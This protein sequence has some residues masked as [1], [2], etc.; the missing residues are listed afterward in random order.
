MA[1]SDKLNFSKSPERI[2][3]FSYGY[4]QSGRNGGD[5]MQFKLHL[6][7][8][9]SLKVIDESTEF[10]DIEKIN[11]KLR[12]DIL[13][14][15]SEILKINSDIKAIKDI[16]IPDIERKITLLDKEKSIEESKHRK[17]NYLLL[18]LNV[19]FFTGLTLFLFYFYTDIIYEVYSGKSKK[20]GLLKWTDFIKVITVNPQYLLAPSIIGA[21]GV[22]IHY[23]IESKYKIKNILV[24]AVIL[25]T[26]IVD[27]FFGYEIHSRMQMVR[28][29]YNLP[30][31]DL[32]SNPDFYK[33][34]V[35]GFL[36]YIFWSILLHSILSQLDKQGQIDRAV[37]HIKNEI[38]K[39]NEKLKILKLQFTNVLPKNVH[40]L[41]NTILKLEKEL[42]EGKHYKELLNS[43][44]T[45]F[46]TGWMQQLQISVFDSQR[47]ECQKILDEYLTK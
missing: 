40:D 11:N 43:L 46:S 12:Q 20:F 16:E 45:K 32:F 37:K 17:P 19:I 28:I 10:D 9:K 39:L 33:V 30:T 35:M 2:D 23:F 14:K 15:K 3:L 38:E 34:I 31:I 4:K 36:S 41:E 47:L 1:T 22:S 7:E 6:D 25:I 29:V 5:S 42:Q 24:C 44:I 18:T 26:L 27:I 13:D 8:I 21:L